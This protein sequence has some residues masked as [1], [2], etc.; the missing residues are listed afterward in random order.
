MGFIE[1][2]Y[3]NSPN[4]SQVNIDSNLN[5]GTYGITTDGE[6]NINDSDLIG[7]NQFVCKDYLGA[8]EAIASNNLRW[9]LT[10]NNVKGSGS[11][12]KKF[13]IPSNFVDPSSVTLK[14]YATNTATTSKHITIYK[15]NQETDIYTSVLQ[16]SINGNI[17]TPTEF[18]LTLSSIKAGEL[19]CFETD[20]ILTTFNGASG[21]KILC[22]LTTVTGGYW[23]VE[24]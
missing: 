9:T 20:H 7:V 21:V 1:T 18:D 8:V 24:E 2:S 10:L 14:F 13:R 12:S 22:D 5:L 6:L 15:Y 3:S 4:L 19:Y 11:Y 23:E 17:S 16:K